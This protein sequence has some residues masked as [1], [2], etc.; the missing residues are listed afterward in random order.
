M[1]YVPSGTWVVSSRKVSRVP[2]AL[3]DTG[4]AGENSDPSWA[5]I[6][7]GVLKSSPVPDSTTVLW[8]PT[9][10][11]AGLIDVYT[12]GCRCTEHAITHTPCMWKLIGSC[13]E[14]YGVTI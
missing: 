12:D 5:N 11:A 4:T 3:T 13:E 7:N 14:L 10:C 2:A 8:G 6:S 9:A 1:S